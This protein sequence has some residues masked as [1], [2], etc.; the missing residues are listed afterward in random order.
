MLISNISFAKPGAK[1]LHTAA[2]PQEVTFFTPRVP[3]V[4]F[5]FYVR[6]FP[7]IPSSVLAL[8]QSTSH[9]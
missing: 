2:T 9:F 1:A 6:P 5:K 8:P 7:P 4:Q 3:H